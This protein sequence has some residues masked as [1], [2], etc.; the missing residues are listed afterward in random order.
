MRRYTYEID[1]DVSAE[2]LFR[3][4]TDIRSWP[5]WDS[6]LETTAFDAPLEPGSTFMLKPKG[7]P[8]V[9]MR[10]VELEAPRRFVDL[11]FLPLAKMRTATEFLPCA[12]GTRV[13]VAIEVFGPLAFLWDRILAR[14]LA[15]DCEHQTKRFIAA[16]EQLS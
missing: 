12:G 2:T 10:I 13:R 14:K 15:A 1:T 8:K 7:G 6:D 16:A 11:A 9:A 3:A 4:K 5:K